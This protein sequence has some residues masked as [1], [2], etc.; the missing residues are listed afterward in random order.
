MMACRRAHH[1]P[2]R[3][4]YRHGSRISHFARVGFHH[5]RR[6]P[7]AK[8]RRHS[9]HFQVAAARSRALSD[10]TPPRELFTLSVRDI[11]STSAGA[12]PPVF[13]ERRRFGEKLSMGHLIITASALKRAAY[14]FSCHYFLFTTCRRLGAMLRADISLAGPRST[15]VSDCWSSGRVYSP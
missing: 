6:R 11:I 2:I 9:R 10:N 13:T 15:H 4:E 12:P 5:G 1:T 3:A 7:R 14:H 8:T